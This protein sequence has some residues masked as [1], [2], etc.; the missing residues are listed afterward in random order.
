LFLLPKPRKSKLGE[1]RKTPF[2]A[3]QTA[4]FQCET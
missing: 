4:L 2:L 1:N 3:F